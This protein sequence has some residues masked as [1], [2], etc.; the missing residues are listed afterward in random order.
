[1]TDGE[2]ARRLAEAGPNLL[3]TDPPPN[4]V[5][6]LAR[7]FDNVLLH[8]LIG[9]AA[10]TAFLEHWLDTGVILGVVLINAIVGFVQ[11]G[12]AEEA[13][14]AIRGMLRVTVRVLRGGSTAEID[15][16]RLVTGDIVTLRAGDRV[17]ADLRILECK[18]LELDESVLTGESVP[19]RKQKEPLNDDTALMDRSNMAY[20][21]TVVTRGTAEALVIA[22]GAVTELGKISG[23][24]EQ[25]GSLSTPV[26][27][28]I[29]AF[30]SRLALLI[31]AAAGAIVLF[32]AFM[33]GH[34]L[35]DMLIAA[36]SI[37]VAAIPEGLPPVITITLA[38]G[39]QMMARRN[40]I[41]RRLPAVETLGEV[42]VICTD[43]TGT[44]T[45]N[46]MT[47]RT[48]ETADGKFA[49]TGIGYKS[50]GEIVARAPQ[51][52]AAPQSLEELVTA[53][54]VCNDSRLTVVDGEAVIV[55]D[56]TEGALIAL[57][58]KIGY[59]HAGVQRAFPRLDVL[60]FESEQRF[61]ASL[62]HAHSGQHVVYVKG[63]PEVVLD[64]CSTELCGGEQRPLRPDYWQDA[65]SASASGGNRV[66][67]MA[68][69]QVPPDAL[70]LERCLQER[71]LTFLGIAG[72]V[73]PPRA[74]VPEALAHCRSAGVRVKMITGDHA[75][76]AAAIGRTL[77]LSAAEVLTSEDLDRL[78]ETEFREAAERVDVFARTR[79]EHKLELVEC[80]QAG[81]RIV[82]MTGDG[83][84]DAPALRRADVGVAMGRKG[85]QAARDASDV[86]LADD[87]FATIVDAIEAGRNIYDNIKKSVVF[88]LPTSVAEALVISLAL[89]FG[90]E[91]PMTP[92]QILWINMITA[93]TLGLALA[94][95]PGDAAI[96]ERAP[97]VSREPLLSRLVVWRTVFVSFLM[98]AGVTYVF[99]TE[100]RTTEYA[101]TACVNALVMFEA[102]Y[103]LSSRF[104]DAYSLSYQGLMGNRLVVAAIGV[105]IVLQLGFTYTPPLQLLF[106]STGLEPT[107][108]LSIIATAFALLLVV[109]AEKWV[110]RNIAPKLASQP[111]AGS[112]GV[113]E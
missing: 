20:A 57:A 44:L 110:R 7:Q 46:Q 91:L 37:A 71:S 21:G 94:F 98:V 107:T 79:P 75:D 81:G 104:L 93:V 60:P 69:G 56:P 25:I 41:V 9:A 113:G 68:R 65:V 52:S 2:A 33:Y 14:R 67:A 90:L 36:V 17:A 13:I 6:R 31:T 80:L 92:V 66:L 42:D 76:T 53:G 82:A 47:V 85:T 38:I 40:A 63:A 55:G 97:S 62:H 10:L 78:T 48:V 43:K 96:M 101:R 112:I 87:N 28:R 35:P 73:D 39:V 15:A 34:P 109:E 70:D 32:A 88:L 59:D 100:A 1:M 105:V 58:G 84:N 18:H 4:A 19:S 5:K 89:V 16:T 102:V 12:R 26:L 11:E 51:S 45:A 61:M 111:S 24:V 74:E 64:M 103:L 86:V 22:T 30:A 72:V 108:W 49:V 27:D 77:G 54:L 99:A 50:D 8:V 23:A 95:E 106:D 3:Q 83:V 29:S